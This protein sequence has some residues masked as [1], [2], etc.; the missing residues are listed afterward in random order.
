MNEFVKDVIS[1]VRASLE[2]RKDKQVNEAVQKFR[3][4]FG[5]D[6]E[7]FGTTTIEGR[8]VQW[9][10]LE[11][12]P[13]DTKHLHELLIQKFGIKRGEVVKLVAEYPVD[14]HNSDWKLVEQH[15]VFCIR[16]VEDKV[17][18]EILIF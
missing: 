16:K 3:E 6:P 5:I 9:A 13:R 12:S 15:E 10:E 7:S 14:E 4:F 1:I 2:R 11:V 8:E 17:A 18:Y